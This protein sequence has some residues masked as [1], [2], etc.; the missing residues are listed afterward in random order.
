MAVAG[1][2]DIT[3]VLRR[4]A[5]KWTVVLGVAAMC[6][7]PTIARASHGKVDTVEMLNGDRFACEIVNLQRGEVTAKTTGF[8]TISIE[9]VKVARITSPARYEVELATGVRLFGELSAPAAGKLRVGPAVGG[10]VVDMIQVIGF[11]PIEASFLRRLD[12]SIDLGFSF[13]QANQLVQWTFN[14]EVSHRTRSVL[15]RLGVSSQLKTEED[16]DEQSRNT[17]SFSSQKDMSDRWFGVGFGQ[18]DQNEEL[19]LRL[20]ST[21][22]AGFGRS[23]LQSNRIILAAFGGI[24]YTREEYGGEPGTNRAEGVVGTRWDWF[25]FGGRKIDLTISALGFVDLTDSSHVRSEVDASMKIDLVK[26]FYWSINLFESYN[27]LPPTGNKKNDFGI[28]VAL[29]LSF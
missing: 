10:V 13:T 18:L 9:W 16:S 8:G 20:R 5:G 24:V 2:R 22:G 25:T 29:G 21:I 14:T 1:S 15:S 26:D 6:A 23:L 27:S 7:S 4:V 11:A 28:T 3:R 17:L 19:G 12:G